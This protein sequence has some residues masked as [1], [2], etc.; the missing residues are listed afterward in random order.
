MKQLNE[1]RIFLL[2]LLLAFFSVLGIRKMEAWGRYQTLQNKT[3]T[4]AQYR[5]D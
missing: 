5:Q 4:E 2:I 1:G 3:V